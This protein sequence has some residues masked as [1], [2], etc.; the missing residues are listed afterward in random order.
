VSKDEKR[1][2]AEARNAR[3]KLLRAARARVSAIESKV[4][5][6]EHRVD[7]IDAQLA[8]PSTYQAGGAARTL[9][10]EKKQLQATLSRLQREWEEAF[11]KVTELEREPPAAG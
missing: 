10:D 6:A 11:S 8:D 7:E 5:A 4:E 3:N 9:G 1:A 2:L